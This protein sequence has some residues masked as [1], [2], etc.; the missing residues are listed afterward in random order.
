MEGLSEA[1][2]EVGG[3]DCRLLLGEWTEAHD[4]VETGEGHCLDI[5]NGAGSPAAPSPGH[6]SSLQDTSNGAGWLLLSH[7]GI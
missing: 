4:W 2:P 6:T 5:E 7:G 3:V 1:H